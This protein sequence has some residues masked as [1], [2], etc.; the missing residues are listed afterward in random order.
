MGDTARNI[1]SIDNKYKAF[2]SYYYHLTQLSESENII[3]LRVYRQY[4]DNKNDDGMKE[5]C[6]VFEKIKGTDSRYL[7]YLDFK[8]G[9]TLHR[10]QNIKEND[11]I[12]DIAKKIVGDVENTVD[13]SN[14]GVK[15][16]FNRFLKFSK[17]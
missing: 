8:K 11:N 1:K 3:P 6:K 12:K 5:I 15:N 4:V 13:N 2:N 10:L 17:I 7:C 9:I 14:Q 16:F